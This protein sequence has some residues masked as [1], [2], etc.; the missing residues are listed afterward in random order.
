[1]ISLRHSCPER[2]RR[3]IP[4][5]SCCCSQCGSNSWQ[6]SSTSQNSS[7]K[8]IVGI[9][10]WLGFVTRKHIAFFERYPHSLI[11]NSGYILTDTCEIVLMY[12]KPKNELMKPLRLGKRQSFAN[13][14][15]QALAQGIEPALDMVRFATVF[16]DRLMT[17]CCENELVR[18]PEITERVAALV[19]QRNAS[20]ELQA[21]GFAPVADKVGHNLACAAAQSDPN[22]PFVG[23][24]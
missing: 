20:P 24:L 10:F 23:F 21:T 17:V 1:M 15:G 4:A 5:V 22:P 14:A 19:D 6:K 12:E 11:P 2:R 9:P 7:S 16:A 18:I 3:L 13:E 8:L